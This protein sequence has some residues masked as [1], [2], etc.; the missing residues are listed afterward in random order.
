MAAARMRR[1]LAGREDMDKSRTDAKGIPSYL[2]VFLHVRRAAQPGDKVLH[3]NSV[4]EYIIFI[5]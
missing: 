4:R 5:I 1:M 3:E 2:R